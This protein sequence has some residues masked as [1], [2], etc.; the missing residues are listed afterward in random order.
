MAATRLAAHCL[1]RR[2]FPKLTDDAGLL[3][4]LET[5]DPRLARRIRE[6]RNLP[7]RA[8]PAPEPNTSFAHLERV[9]PFPGGLARF[10][11][12]AIAFF[13]KCYSHL[14]VTTS[15]NVLEN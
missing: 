12:S 10:G 6:W 7:G 15:A 5:T 3:K 14:H 1:I 8:A 4:A 13:R 11:L 9:L 2:Y